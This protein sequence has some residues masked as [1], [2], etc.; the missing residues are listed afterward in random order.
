MVYY[1]FVNT[2]FLEKMELSVYCDGNTGGGDAG[3]L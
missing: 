3:P 1:V 2:Q